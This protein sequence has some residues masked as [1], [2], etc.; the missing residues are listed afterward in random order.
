MTIV[1]IEM[2]VRERQEQ[3]ASEAA[4]ASLLHLVP[5]APSL[6]V[7]LAE[8]L[9]ALVKRLDTTRVYSNAP[10]VCGCQEA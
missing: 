2:R 3:F 4:R 5:R 9:Y 7:R 6:R 10:R 8:T 1:E